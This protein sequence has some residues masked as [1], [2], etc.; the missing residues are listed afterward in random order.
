MGFKVVADLC[1]LVRDGVGAVLEG[2]ISPGVARDWTGRAHPR[3]LEFLVRPLDHVEHLLLGLTGGRP[4]CEDDDQERLLELVGSCRTEEERLDDLGVQLGPERGQA[5]V[6]GLA[7]SWTGGKRG[8]VPENLTCWTRFNAAC[9]ELIPL[10][11]TREFMN[12]TCRTG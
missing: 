9:G 7:T 10:P 8:S 2:L 5:C 6:G 11:S 12:R 4:V 3:S 1:E